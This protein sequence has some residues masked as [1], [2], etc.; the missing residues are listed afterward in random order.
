MRLPKPAFGVLLVAGAVAV[1]GALFSLPWPLGA[2][3]VV[4]LAV[5]ALHPLPA[6]P[7]LPGPPRLLLGA[8][9]LGLALAVLL[10]AWT[11]GA[12][13]SAID[14]ASL[15][16][17]VALDH[18]AGQYR[19]QTLRG[20]ASAGCELLA[21]AAFAVALTRMR[22]PVP[23]PVLT[24]FATL[25]VIA[26]AMTG[27][28]IA[29]WTTTPEPVMTV[30]ADLPPELAREVAT[31]VPGQMMSLD[32]FGAIILGIMLYATFQLVD[33]YARGDG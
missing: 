9:L 10:Q 17:L 11:L 20:L 27:F 23:R 3:W 2:G 15:A 26:V 6:R 30:P 25:A 33:G 22:R 5:L 18:D 29:A 19:A 32:P 28:A 4:A 7:V 31:T 13:R 12:F 1:V 21:C 24:G 8:G 14:G 16:D